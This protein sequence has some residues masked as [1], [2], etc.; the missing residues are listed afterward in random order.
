MIPK[1]F[2]NELNAE[3][4]IFFTRAK[5]ALSIKDSRIL[6]LIDQIAAVTLRGGDRQRPY[7]CALSFNSGKDSSLAKILPVLL[8]LELLHTYFLIHDD[9]VDRASVRREGPTIH[10]YFT[11]NLRKQSQA[12]ALAILAGDLCCSWAQ[13]LWD[14]IP[15]NPSVLAAHKLFNQM[16]EEVILGQTL[17]ASSMQ[18]A[19]ETQLLSMYRAKSGNYS[20][21]IPLLIGATLAGKKAYYQ[22]LSGFGEAAGVAFQL[23][24]DLLGVFGNKSKTGKSTDSD[25]KEGKWT[26]LAHYAFKKLT[27]NGQQKFLNILGN[28]RASQTGCAWVKTVFVKT[29]AKKYVED[30]TW[31]L[32]NTAKKEVRGLPQPLQMKLAKMANFIVNRSI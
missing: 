30:V 22:N 26:V 12:Q 6:E 15:S 2:Q 31:Q 25:I 11:Q 18:H 20:V 4:K 3:L 10:A 17:D 1:S 29:G 19:G 23:K 5:Q 8:S 9:I 14:Q 27:R 28:P 32:V 24:D 21:K 13:Q 16:D 7:L